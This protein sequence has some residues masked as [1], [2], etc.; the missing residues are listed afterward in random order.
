M[1]RAVFAPIFGGSLSARLYRRGRSELR[2]K[3]FG[4][5]QCS[6]VIDVIHTDK[7]DRKIEE[8]KK[9]QEEKR[10]S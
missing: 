6:F 5:F 2:Q 1:Y 3:C 8:R 7:D 4:C 9:R 10:D